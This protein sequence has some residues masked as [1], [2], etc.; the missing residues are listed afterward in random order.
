M[1][2]RISL[3][4]RFLLVLSLVI[5]ALLLLIG[6]VYR[7][8]CR[9]TPFSPQTPVESD[10]GFGWPPQHGRQ[11]GCVR[12]GPAQQFAQWIGLGPSI[13]DQITSQAQRDGKI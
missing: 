2:R 10:W 13:E 11:L 12:N 5:V 7:E 8:H 3:T 9:A 4:P 1:D 6:P